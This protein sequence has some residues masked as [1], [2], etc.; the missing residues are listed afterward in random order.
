V[1][2][3]VLSVDSIVPKDT[4]IYTLGMFERWVAYYLKR[5][6]RSLVQLGEESNLEGVP[7]SLFVLLSLEDEGDYIDC[8]TSANEL[9]RF[10]NGKDKV[11]LMQVAKGSVDYALQNC[12]ENIRR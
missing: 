12:G 4:K 5:G 3:F 9:S 8:F 1:K 10:D 6:G 2:P 11:A 7:E